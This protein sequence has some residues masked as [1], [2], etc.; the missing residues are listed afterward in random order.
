MNW[1]K[2][3][4]AGDAFGLC[5]AAERGEVNLEQRDAA[6]PRTNRCRAW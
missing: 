6:L 5:P 4:L 1:W 2:P 3:G